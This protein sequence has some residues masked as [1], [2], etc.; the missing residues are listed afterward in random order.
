MKK[1]YIALALG[2]VLSLTLMV[3]PVK[4]DTIQKSVSVIRE[5]GHP[6]APVNTIIQQMGGTVQRNE[7]GKFYT[8]TIN[9]KKL[10]IDDTWSFAEVDGKLIPYETRTLG[11]FT[12][13]V[14]KTPIIKDGNVYV[15]V[16]FLKTSVGLQLDVKDDKV[17][18]NKVGD[19]NS[20]TSVATVKAPSTGG[21][22]SSTNGGSGNV[23]SNRPVPKPTTPASNTN[24]TPVVTPKP[25]T[26]P[27][28]KPVYTGSTIKEKLYSLGFLQSGSNMT[29]NKYGKE[30]ADQ[31]DSISFGFGSGS[32]DI[33][34]A[35]F[36]S[37]PEIDQKIKT[38]FNW[39]L[40]SQ[41]GK[42]Y[43]I[44]DNPNLKSQTIQLDGR[45]INIEV[46]NIAVN[47]S[48]SPIK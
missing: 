8:F 16:D 5:S 17:T 43:S 39:I 3:A 13:P 12:I 19:E 18:F 26:K 44:L 2:T 30:G 4:A 11:G 20:T 36:A 7:T 24:T 42:L 15:P 40:P 35:I 32:I 45:T 27:A 38:I 37:N 33:D 14:F 23:E 1:N 47:V 29:L 25:P 10:R 34:M 46:T 9:G 31:F 41:G 6:Y 28:N 22:Q 48:F 21:T